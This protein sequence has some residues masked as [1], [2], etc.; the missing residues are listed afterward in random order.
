VTLTIEGLGGDQIRT[1]TAITAAGSIIASAT[2]TGTLKGGA[3][4]EFGIQMNKTFR[5]LDNF[6]FS[7]VPEPSNSGLIFAL[8]LSTVLVFRSC[9]RRK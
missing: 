8:S 2:M 7:V 4:Y 6:T 9:K 1:T 5:G 3:P